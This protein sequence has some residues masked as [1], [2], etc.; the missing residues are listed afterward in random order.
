MRIPQPY[1]DEHEAVSYCMGSGD[2]SSATLEPRVSK[3]VYLLKVT[4]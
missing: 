2:N 4:A 1:I 3:P